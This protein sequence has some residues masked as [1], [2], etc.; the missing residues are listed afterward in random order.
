MWRVSL[1]LRASRHNLHVAQLLAIVIV[2]ER[3]NL[4]LTEGI[5]LTPRQPSVAK[6][7]QPRTV[8]VSSF[9]LKVIL[10]H[11]IALPCRGSYS[12]A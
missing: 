8:W 2:R 7:T 6:W 9:L 4:T 1:S 12:A 3:R 5:D 11:G 10:G